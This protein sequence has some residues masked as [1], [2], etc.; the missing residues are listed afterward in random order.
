[1][2]IGNSMGINTRL[3]KNVKITKTVNEETKE[4][5]EE[6]RQENTQ[7]YQKP[8]PA[9]DV[10][11]FMANQSMCM[12][13]SFTKTIN[14][15]KFV[16]EE[17]YSRIGNMMREFEASVEN[18]LKTFDGEFPNVKIS[19]KSKIYTILNSLERTDI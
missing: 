3:L 14:V 16:N 17:Q 4:V 12:K 5:V 18:R 1:M 7:I 2:D 15:K 9:D 8:I 19:E 10:L 6:K 11:K 13:P